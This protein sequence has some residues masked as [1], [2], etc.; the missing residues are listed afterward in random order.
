MPESLTNWCTC[1]GRAVFCL[2]FLRAERAFSA[3]ASCIKRARKGRLTQEE[4]GAR[5]SLSRTSIT[6]IEKGRQK[7]LLHTLADIAE[8]LQVA[9]VKLLPQNGAE[10][11]MGLDDALRD[12]PDTEREWIM[13]AV[14]TI[15][16]GS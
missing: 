14:T 5:V 16:K 11:E 3:L 10:S 1:L 15:R 7:I 4:L 13:S 6:N 8:A 12:R 2:D 9:P